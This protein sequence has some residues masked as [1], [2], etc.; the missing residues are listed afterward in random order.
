MSYVDRVYKRVCA[1]FGLCMWGFGGAT[2]A[3]SETV[4]IHPNPSGTVGVQETAPYKGQKNLRVIL[5]PETK[6]VGTG[7]FNGWKNLL[8][9]TCEGENGKDGVKIGAAAFKD[10]SNLSLVRFAKTGDIGAS[11]FEGCYSLAMLDVS[12][13]KNIFIFQSAFRG[14][15]SLL[16]LRV[17]KDCYW[18][19]R[20]SALE[21]CRSS[22]RVVEQEAN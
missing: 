11:A 21:G 2:A 3:R 8:S 22:L 19:D 15:V 4:D 12:R 13:S 18:V 20:E 14:C 7:A 17:R 10:C 6:C 9:V 5:T 1:I 16:E